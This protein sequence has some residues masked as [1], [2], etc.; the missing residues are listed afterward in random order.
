MG[1]CHGSDGKVHK[2]RS[3][4]GAS[5]DEKKKKLEQRQWSEPLQWDGTSS[6]QA[7]DLIDATPSP[8]HV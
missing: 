3:R 1:Q 2:K 6:I 8:P 7:R 4:F 5:R